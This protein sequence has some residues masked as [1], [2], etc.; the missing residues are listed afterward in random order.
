MLFIG[1]SGVFTEIQDSLNYIWGIQA[2]PRKGFTKFIKNRIM[3]FSMIGSVGF[4][5]L[6]GLIVNAVMDLLNKKL[7]S[8]YSIEALNVFYYLNFF[9]VFIII[10]ILFTVIFRTL[11]DGKLKLKDC[12]I[13]AAFTSLLFMLGKYAIG[14]YLS[15]SAMA[16]A[17]GAA[18]SLILI[19]VWVYYSFI[20]FSVYR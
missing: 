12:A 9:I 4:L 1:A 5:L 11:P 14:A 10:A 20:I 19:L 8:M 7:A 15:S 16:T 17:Y 6:V 2:K 13:G 18:G 3:S